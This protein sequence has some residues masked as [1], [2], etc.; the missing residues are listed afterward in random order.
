MVVG[1]MAL[2]SMGIIALIIAGY[3]ILAASFIFVF[4]VP[5]LTRGV[6]LI[7]RPE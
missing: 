6:W 7:F 5:L 2:S 4:A 1:S 3:G